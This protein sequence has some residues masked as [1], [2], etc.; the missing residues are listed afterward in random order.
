L[1]WLHTTI[2]DA[3]EPVLRAQLD[4]LQTE[5]ETANDQ[6]DNNFSR[7]EAAGLS[8]VALAEKLAAAED[9]ISELEDELRALGQ[10]NIASLALV[11]AQRDE[12]GLVP[13]PG[14]AKCS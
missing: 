10:R 6:L 4:Y 3:N 12:N 7:L 2:G 9:R 8:G 1:S 13:V 14:T 5:L 11:S